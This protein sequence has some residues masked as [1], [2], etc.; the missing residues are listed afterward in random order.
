M[1]EFVENLIAK[2]QSDV[3]YNDGAEVGA[4]QAID[5]VNQLAEAYKKQ[6][7]ENGIAE[8]S[9]NRG[10]NDFEL[11]VRMD[12]YMAMKENETEE[13]AKARFYNEFKT[14]NMTTESSMQLYEFEVQA[15]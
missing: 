4:K 9:E 12:F 6:T 1:K 3:N 2:L 14:E 15:C 10:A 7:H 11:R 13:E 5:I 8:V